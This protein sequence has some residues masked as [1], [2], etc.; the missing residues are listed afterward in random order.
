MAITPRRS[1]GHHPARSHPPLACIAW[2]VDT[3]RRQP[4]GDRRPFD[5][6]S[7]Y[8][9]ADAAAISFLV[10]ASRPEIDV[11]VR[12]RW[13]EKRMTEKREQTGVPRVRFFCHPCFCPFRFESEILAGSTPS[14][15][16]SQAPTAERRTPAVEDAI[17]GRADRSRR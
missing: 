9:R 4:I 2:F 7:S 1:W 10:S 15:F 13:T 11:P 3:V 5:L 12:F 8:R 14:E 6:R 16:L 17:A